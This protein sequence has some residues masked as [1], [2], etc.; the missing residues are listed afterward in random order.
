MSKQPSVKYPPCAC[1]HNLWAHRID[2][3][4]G[5]PARCADCMSC[6]G[7]TLVE[8]PGGLAELLRCRTDGEDTPVDAHVADVAGQKPP[9]QPEPNL[10]RA[11]DHIGRVLRTTY[12]TIQA[13]QVC[14]TC[15]HLEVR[16]GVPV[17]KQ[18]IPTPQRI[19]GLFGFR[20]IPTC[21]PLTGVPFGCSGHSG[22]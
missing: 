5:H 6:T 14:E 12:E 8:M 1:G 19:C 11:L 21:S 22:H 20:E 15:R 2:D 4:R 10:T 9:I 18:M 17:G 7:Y 16:P 3:G 13:N